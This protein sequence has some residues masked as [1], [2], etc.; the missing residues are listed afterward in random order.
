MTLFYNVAVNMM[1]MWIY[2]PAVCEKFSKKLSRCTTQC[3][4]MQ[5]DKEFNKLIKG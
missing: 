1:L 4:G 3:H 5:I 2:L